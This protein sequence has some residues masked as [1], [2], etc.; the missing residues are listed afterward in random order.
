MGCHDTFCCICGNSCYPLTNDSIKYTFSPLVQKNISND[1]I[2]QIVKNTKWFNKCTLLLKN[3]KIVHN[4]K[5]ISC[6]RGFK[7]TKTG[8]YYESMNYYHNDINM[9]Q[10]YS[11]HNNHDYVENS[12]I[13]IH[14]D[15]WKFI[16]IN[17]NIKL[18]YK[19]LPIKFIKKL[20]MKEE[21]LPIDYNPI[22]KYW[23]QDFNYE[24]MYLDNNTWI[25]QNPLSPD[26]DDKNIKRIKKII[27]QLKL[28]QEINRIGPSASA[29]FYKNNDIKLGN[30]NKFWKISNTKWIEITDCIVTK[31]I[32]IKNIP[33]QIKYI[34]YIKKIPQIGEVNIE[35]LFIKNYVFNKINKSI[36]INF[37]GTK[38]TIS[39]LL[40]AENYNS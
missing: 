24:K 39:K 17:Y 25:I 37:I 4:C 28:S 15:C 5:E 1:E 27:N 2:K 18:K 26:C 6:N 30:N 8:K 36:E 22:S 11:K 32:L 9:E 13:F 31:N 34:N 10:Y 21:L 16:K 19:D 23:M 12:G 14:T 35:P 3:N 20:L 29:T 33:A 38:N 40:N 7:S